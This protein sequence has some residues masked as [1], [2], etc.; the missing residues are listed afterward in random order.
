MVTPDIPTLLESA[1]EPVV[2]FGA[3]TLLETVVDRIAGQGRAAHEVWLPPLDQAPTIDMLV[4]HWRT[5]QVG[6]LEFPLGIVDRPYDQRRDILSVDVSGSRG[7]VAIVEQYHAIG[8]S[9][10][11]RAM[12][13]DNRRA[14]THNGAHGLANFAFLTGVDGRRGIIEHEH[15]WVGNDGA[16]NSDALTLTT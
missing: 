8:K 13:D 2:E 10:S 6:L 16:S 11:A 12:G 14:T 15:P 5:P 9:N 7:N 1:P 3:R 4:P